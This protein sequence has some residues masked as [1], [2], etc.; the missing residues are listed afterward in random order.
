[1]DLKSP[2]SL[3]KV[4]NELKKLILLTKS[5]DFCQRKYY[6]DLYLN[7]TQGETKW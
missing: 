6:I 2:K 3:K 5:I 7:L 1:M 4:K